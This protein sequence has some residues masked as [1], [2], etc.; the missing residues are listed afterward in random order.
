MDYYDI[1]V[2]VPR[3]SNHAINLDLSPNGDINP[4]FSHTLF[5]SFSVGHTDKL[6]MSQF[7]E[8]DRLPPRCIISCEI[9][10]IPDSSIQFQTIFKAHFNDH[11]NVKIRADQ[12]YMIRLIDLKTASFV[13]LSGENHFVPSL[14]IFK[15]LPHDP[16]VYGS[17]ELVKRLNRE[18]NG[19]LRKIAHMGYKLEHLNHMFVFDVDR[20]GI[21][22]FG[23]ESKADPHHEYYLEYNKHNIMTKEVDVND[24]LLKF[25]Q[26]SASMQQQQQQQQQSPKKDGTN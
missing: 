6:I 12:C 23:A 11:P 14:K 9:E 21:R 13:N 17:N 8:I 4:M 10:Q 20:V 16:L 26:T 2:L 1:I 7:R 15:G 22:V 3:T 18:K 19:L 5:T 25:H 24:F